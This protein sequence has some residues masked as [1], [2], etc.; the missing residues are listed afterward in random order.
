MS[1]LPLLTSWSLQ[2]GK[3]HER[4]KHKHLP[5]THKIRSLVFTLFSFI[6][7][8]IHPIT[9]STLLGGYNVPGLEMDMRDTEMKKVGFCPKKISLWWEKDTRKN[10]YITGQGRLCQKAGAQGRNTEP[11]PCGRACTPLYLDSLSPQN[12]NN[13]PTF[14][15]LYALK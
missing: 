13:S 7:S 10:N 3:Q 6:H 11:K 2:H 9:Y 12:R 15:R 14:S 1:P 4:S 5:E 8:F